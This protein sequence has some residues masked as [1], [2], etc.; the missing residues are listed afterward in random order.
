MI[1]KLILYF[2]CFACFISQ[3]LAQSPVEY[4][5]KPAVDIPIGSIIIGSFTAA[6][7]KKKKNKPFT[8]F[9]VNELAY[10]VNKFDYSSINRNYN[11][12][13][14]RV[15]DGALLASVLTPFIL[16]AD[17]K[18]RKQSKYIIPIGFEAC[19]LNI[20]LT[21]M[22]KE[23]TQR[24]R[25]FVYNDDVPMEEKLTGNARKSFFS[26]HTSLAATGTFFTA[27]VYTQ[28]NPKS[29]WTPLV[30]TGAAAFPLGV[31]AMRYGGGKH[32]WSD[33]LVGYL[34]GAAI[35]TLVPYLHHNKV[36]QP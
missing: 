20:A 15:S 1:K 29:K 32:F 27:M 11:H 18:V 22:T 3:T 4:R 30:W 6:S 25:P 8:E 36:H 31:G 10:S 12:I 17:K 5:F 13:I 34:V 19:L 2:A 33:I 7:I 23:F 21:G 28:M 9:E 14:H 24:T 26:G 16:L 35:G